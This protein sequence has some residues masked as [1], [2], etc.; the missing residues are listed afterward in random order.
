MVNQREIGVDSE[1]YAEA[2]R[3][4]L[5]Q[6]PDIILV[7]E[8]RDL[9]TIA[10]ALTAAETGHLVLSTLHTTGA[11]K[12]IDRIIDVF[13]PFQQPQIRMQLSMTLVGIVSQQLLIST[14]KKNRVAA[15]EV[16]LATPAIRNLIREAKVHQ[17]ASAMQAAANT[18]MVLM[19]NS[20]S[21]LYRQGKI[22]RDMAIAYSIDKNYIKTMI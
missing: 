18:G 14:D 5:R 17:V 21:E 16:L 6:D 10:I 7:G 13:P 2:L 9:E 3:A 20:L 4:G 11:A 22:S 15:A 12:T 19:D 1:S 8:M